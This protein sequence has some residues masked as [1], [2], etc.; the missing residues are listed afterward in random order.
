M[1][2]RDSYREPISPQEAIFELRRVS[3]T[4]LD[5]RFVEAFIEVLAENDTAYRQGRDVDF[6]TE[7]ALDRTIHDYA[8]AT[9]DVDAVAIGSREPN[10]ASG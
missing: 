3:G 1:T 7:L 9:P 2:A 8:A 5:S 10:A 4:Q 6:E